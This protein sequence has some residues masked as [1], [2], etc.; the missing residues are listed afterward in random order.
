MQEHHRKRKERQLAAETWRGPGE[1][2]ACP[3]PELPRETLARCTGSRREGERGHPG[4][5]G[6]P[7]ADVARSGKQAD[8]GG[9]AAN[10]PSPPSRQ[11]ACLLL[12]PHRSQSFR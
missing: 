4:R 12:A 9:T 5:E 8:G 7:R 11:N 10:A 3:S 2:D 1:R 6:A